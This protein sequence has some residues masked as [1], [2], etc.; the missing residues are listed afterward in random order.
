MRKIS[1]YWNL[2]RLKF[3]MIKTFNKLQFKKIFKI[4][5]IEINKESNNFKL[6]QLFF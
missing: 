5:L 3:N 1:N 6:N 4:N 2:N